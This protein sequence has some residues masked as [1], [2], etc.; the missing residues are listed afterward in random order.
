MI[1]RKRFKSVVLAVTCGAVVILIAV[2]AAMRYMS[3]TDWPR[4]MTSPRHFSA[5]IVAYRQLLRMSSDA[6]HRKIWNYEIAVEPAPPREIHIIYAP[7]MNVDAS[8]KN[9]EFPGSHI[10]VNPGTETHVILDKKT[11]TVRRAYFAE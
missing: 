6:E 10:R 1:S 7:R 11:L 5:T 8:R 2:V 3:P 9:S 4:I